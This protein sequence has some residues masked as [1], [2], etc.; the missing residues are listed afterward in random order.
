[1]AFYVYILRCADDSYYTGH[2]DSLAARLAA[3]EQGAIPGYTSTRCPVQLV[4]AQDFPSREQAL[5][6][7]RRI[8]RWTR[9]KKEALVSK[10]W[11]RLT[12]LAKARGF[13]RL[14]TSG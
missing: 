13:D 12:A 1:M 14:T 6:Q 7:E 3:H 9:A 11:S 8:K 10:D 2:T 4:F 5:V